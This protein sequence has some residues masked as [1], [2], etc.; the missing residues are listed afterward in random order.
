MPFCVFVSLEVNLPPNARS[1][2]ITKRA[3]PPQLLKCFLTLKKKKQK[4]EEEGGRKGELE[5][6]KSSEHTSG[7]IKECSHILHPDPLALT[8]PFCTSAF[9]LFPHECVGMR[10]STQAWTYI[11]FVSAVNFY[12]VTT[13]TE[14]GSTEKLLQKKAQEQMG[15][16][17]ATVLSSYLNQSKWSLAS[18]CVCLNLAYSVLATNGHWACNQL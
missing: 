15:F 6:K 13:N 10:V 11:V 7:T 16:L 17:W 3:F 12:E 4:E 5:G 2:W 9:S 18:L 14:L 8:F 1:P